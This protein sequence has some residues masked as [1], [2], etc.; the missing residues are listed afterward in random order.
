MTANQLSVQPSTV[1]IPAPLFSIG[2]L[3]SWNDEH[4]SHKSFQGVVVQQSY[5]NDYRGGNWRYTMA[6]TVAEISGEPVSYH[7]GNFGFDVPEHILTHDDLVDP[8]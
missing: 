5:C 8:Y 2:E 7:A 6:I 3:V 4:R 1:L